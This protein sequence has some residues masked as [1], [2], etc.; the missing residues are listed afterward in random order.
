MV[1]SEGIDWRAE[2]DRFMALAYTRCERAARR[3]FK[4]WHSRKRDDA[5]QEALE[6][7]VGSM[8]AAPRSRERSGAH[9]RPADPLGHHLGPL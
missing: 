9:D 4:K 7:D 8:E 6:Q 1:T 5:V 3:A 2:Q